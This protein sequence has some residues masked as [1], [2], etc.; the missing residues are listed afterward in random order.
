MELTDGSDIA[1]SDGKFEMTN[2]KQDACLEARGILMES[3]RTWEKSTRRRWV[4]HEITNG[5]GKY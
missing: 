4:L 5:L 1:S 3:V 2:L